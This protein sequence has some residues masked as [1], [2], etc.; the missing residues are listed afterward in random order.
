M[1]AVSWCNKMR[2]QTGDIAGRS[3]VVGGAVPDLFRLL[4]QNL[5]GW[6]ELFATA[7]ILVEAPTTKLEQKYA[8][9]RA[10]SQVPSIRDF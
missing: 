6:A 7:V 10:R 9:A 4:V 3:T 5:H 2:S 1:I 8:V